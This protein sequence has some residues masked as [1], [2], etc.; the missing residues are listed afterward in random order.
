[1]SSTI[2]RIAPTREDDFISGEAA[3]AFRLHVSQVIPGDDWRRWTREAVDVELKNAAHTNDHIQTCFLANIT[4][5]LKACPTVRIVWCHRSDNPVQPPPDYAV[6][7]DFDRHSTIVT[8][9]QFE[10]ARRMRMHPAC[11]AVGLSFYVRSSSVAVGMADI[12]MGGSCTP[13]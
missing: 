10:M 11:Q 6:R 7:L 5:F 13:L 12:F 1:M 8:P 2:R 9:L 4:G 3:S